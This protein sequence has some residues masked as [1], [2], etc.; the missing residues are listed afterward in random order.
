MQTRLASSFAILAAVGSTAAPVYAAECRL[1]GDIAILLMKSGSQCSSGGGGQDGQGDIWKQPPPPIIGPPVW[2]PAEGSTPDGTSSFNSGGWKIGA[3][4]DF[5][6]DGECDIVWLRETCPEGPEKGIALTL[7]SSD[8]V[9]AMPQEAFASVPSTWKLVGSGQFVCVPGVSCPGDLLADNVQDLVWWNPGNRHLEFWGSDGH[10]AF[11]DTPDN[12]PWFL[13]A[14]APWT[15]VAAANL[16]GAGLPEILWRN[17]VSGNLVYWGLGYANGPLAHETGGL[18]APSQPEETHWTLRAASDLNHDGKEDLLFQNVCSDA[19]V[20]WYMDGPMRITGD[21]LYPS[22]FPP[23]DA[24]CV[25]GT[26]IGLHWEIVG[27]R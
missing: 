6:G 14:P 7:T 18:L 23:H 19:G 22:V 9:I 11:P 2:R 24:K 3:T 13:G 21:F 10:G 8:G 4:A 27:P 25:N 15:P 20:V 12:R 17:D 5:S 1:G 16:D 26:P